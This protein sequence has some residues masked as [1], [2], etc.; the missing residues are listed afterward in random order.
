[1]KRHLPSTSLYWLM[2]NRLGVTIR[3]ARE[4]LKNEKVAGECS[5]GT[6]H[7]CQLHHLL[8][9]F[10][11]SDSQ[12]CHALAH[13]K[14]TTQ[15]GRM[16]WLVFVPS[17]THGSALHASSCGMTTHRHHP[18]FEVLRQ[19]ATG[20]REPHVLIAQPPVEV[21]DGLHRNILPKCQLP[22]F[23]HP[24]AKRDVFLPSRFRHLY[25]GHLLSDPFNSDE[26]LLSEDSPKPHTLRLMSAISISRR[27][28]RHL[29]TSC[30]TM[31]V[32][33]R[34]RFVQYV[35][36]SRRPGILDNTSHGFLLTHAHALY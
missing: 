19:P 25:H 12:R 33:V 26:S 30:S 23:L 34:N 20:C 27:S 21:H 4:H 29:F 31:A 18:S 8:H 10:L 36:I 16:G 5:L 11:Q 17:S 32:I 3:Q 1:M 24:I 2:S 13:R 9:L 6:S 15:S 7:W 35:R 28:S 22:I 14:L